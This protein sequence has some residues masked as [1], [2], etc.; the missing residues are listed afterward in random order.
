M[1]GSRCLFPWAV[2]VAVLALVALLPLSV[3]F[4]RMSRVPLS[5]RLSLLRGRRKFVVERHYN[6]KRAICSPK[7]SS[8]PPPNSVNDTVDVPTWKAPDRVWRHG[9]GLAERSRT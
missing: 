3:S 6:P 1:R 4:A 8:C 7:A 5:N 9:P 2:S